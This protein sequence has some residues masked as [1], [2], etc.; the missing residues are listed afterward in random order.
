MGINRCQLLAHNGLLLK[1]PD[2]FAQLA[3]DLVLVGEQVFYASPFLDQFFGSLLSYSRYAGDIV[4][5]VAHET[6][7]INYL[8]H[9]IY[10]PAF[11]DLFHAQLFGLIAHIGRTELVQMILNQ[12]PEILIGSH[13]KNLKTRMSRFFSNSAYHI[14]SFIAIEAQVGD[15]HSFCQLYNIGHGNGDIL[16]LFLALGFVFRKGSMPE[17]RFSGIIYDADMGWFFFVENLEQAVGKPENRRS[18][19]PFGVDP[20][21]FDKSEMR[22]V[23]Q[24]ESIEEKEFFGSVGHVI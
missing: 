20:R 16:R 12:L 9:I 15:T 17:G 3:G 7:D 18:I 23:Y 21:V 24:R 10:F 19:H 1:I 11:L 22:P 2:I 14:V 13:H 5:T 6:Q 4:N 8:A